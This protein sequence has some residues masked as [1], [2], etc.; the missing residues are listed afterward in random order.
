MNGDD[1]IYHLTGV[2]VVA[3]QKW[4]KNFFATFWKKEKK[5][6]RE[7]E[8]QATLKLLGSRVEK[9]G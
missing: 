4:V 6:E 3:Q 9:Q 2:P 7:K 8:K 1:K 5:R